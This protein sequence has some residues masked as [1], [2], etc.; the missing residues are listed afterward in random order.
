MS[1]YNINV[2]GRPL[3]EWVDKEITQEIHVLRGEI[4][5]EREMMVR[6]PMKVKCSSVYR[7]RCSQ[8]RYIDPQT[9]EVK[10][11]EVRKEV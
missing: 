10:K 4:M 8:V 11:M 6:Q 9:M 7:G 3:R 1:S 2:N 5:R